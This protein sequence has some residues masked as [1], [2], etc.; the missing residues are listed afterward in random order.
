M[1]YAFALVS[2]EPP[3]DHLSMLVCVYSDWV[4]ESVPAHMCMHVCECPAYICVHID[5]SLATYT[6]DFDVPLGMSQA[7]AFWLLNELSLNLMSGNTLPRHDRY[8]V[9]TKSSGMALIYSISL[10]QT[11]QNTGNDTNKTPH[12]KRNV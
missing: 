8:G 1:L 9:H 5:M 2:P 10:G 6:S 3:L 4:Y 11:P 7:L 12:N